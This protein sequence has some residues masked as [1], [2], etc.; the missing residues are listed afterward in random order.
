M[1]WDL[2]KDWQDARFDPGWVQDADVHL[3]HA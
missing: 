3:E 2:E 1:Y